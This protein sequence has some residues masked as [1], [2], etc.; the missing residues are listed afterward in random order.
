MIGL[1]LGIVTLVSVNLHLLQLKIDI[2]RSIRTVPGSGPFIRQ[3]IDPQ[4]V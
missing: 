3:V 2:L 4:E 1:V